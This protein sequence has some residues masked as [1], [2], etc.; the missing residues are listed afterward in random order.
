MTNADDILTQ[1]EKF[2]FEPCE[3]VIRVSSEDIP[4]VQKALK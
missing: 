2:E 4:Q 3:D 1:A